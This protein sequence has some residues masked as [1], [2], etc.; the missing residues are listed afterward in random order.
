MFGLLF[1]ILRRPWFDDDEAALD[2]DLAE[3]EW[4]SAAELGARGEARL[5]RLVWRAFL[6]APVFSDAWAGLDAA[7]ILAEPPR[8]LLASLPRAGRG[9]LLDAQLAG[10]EARRRAAFARRAVRWRASDDL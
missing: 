4:L 9:E 2:A 1:E 5:R 7:R 10:D 6:D 3:S 8:Q